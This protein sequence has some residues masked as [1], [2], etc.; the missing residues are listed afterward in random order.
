MSSPLKLRAISA[1]DLTVMSALLQDAAIGIGN[2]TWLAGERRFALIA[3]RFIHEKR[4]WFRKPK[5]ERTRSGLHFSGVMR[6]TTHDID[7]ADKDRIL[8]LLAIRSEAGDDGAAIIQLDFSG[9]A[10]IR[11]EVECIDAILSD[12]GD[13]W[14]ALARPHHDE[15]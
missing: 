9:G 13:T 11:L 5:G 4:R 12:I 2:L 1:E 15:A 14:D 6:V 3:S 10:A 8:G 7:L